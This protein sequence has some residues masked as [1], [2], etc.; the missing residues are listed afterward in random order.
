MNSEYITFSLQGYAMNKRLLTLF[1]AML[2]GCFAFAPVKAGILE[3][4]LLHAVKKSV[5]SAP[6][7]PLYLYAATIQADD[8]DNASNAL[9]TK[10]IKIINLGPA[11]NTGADEYAPTVTA[12]GKTLFFVSNRK[13][14][15]ASDEVEYRGPASDDFWASKKE[16]RLDE[17]QADS[18][19]NIEPEPKDSKST[20]N[21][22]YN[23]G[24]ASISSDGQRLIFT[25]CDRPDGIGSCD[26][27]QTEIDGVKW[28]RPS[29]LG[30]EVNS[31]FWDS[32]PSLSPD[33][34]RIYFASNRLG[35]NNTDS[36]PG[37]TN[38][39][40]WYSDFDEETMKWKPAKNLGNIVN[41]AGE[42]LG[43]FI[44]KDGVTLYFASTGHQPNLG[45][46][47]FYFATLTDPE[48]NVWSKPA[49]IPYPGINSKDDEE[50]ISFP[51][52]GD[53]IYFSSDRSYE[54][55]QGG[56]DIFMAY[57]PPFSR[58]VIIRVLVLDECTGEGIPAAVTIKNKHMGTSKRD[59]L[60]LGKSELQYIV[61]NSDY[62]TG[63]KASEKIEFE[64]VAEN[65]KY[66][67]KS[68]TVTI[69]KPEITYDEEKA[70]E[71][72]EEPP[73]RIMLG[74][75]PSITAEMEYADYIKRVSKKNPSLANWKGLVL[76]EVA[77][78]DLFPL[79]P[80]VFFD[81]TSSAMHP[82]YRLFSSPAQTAGFT[83]ETVKGD[84]N[85][86]TPEKYYD[87]LNIYGYRLKKYPS[88]SVTVTGCN[89]ETSPGEKDL[90]L[91]QRRAQIVYDY[92]KNVWG[93]EESRMKLEKRNL[94]DALVASKT[95]DKDPQSKLYSNIENRRTELTFASSSE[96]DLWQVR[97]PL[98]D[99]EPTIFPTPLTM[100]FQ[101]DNGIDEGLVDSRRIE[102]KRGDAGWVTL[103]NVGKSEKTFTWDWKN[104]AGANL[105]E[106]IFDEASFSARLVVKSINGTECTSDPISIK[107]MIVKN[108]PGVKVE[109]AGAKTRETY[110]LVL[111][112]FNRYDAGPFNERIMKEFVFTRTMP[113]SEIAV[114]GHTD[115][116][117]M[118]ESNAKLST[119][120]AKTV[121][122]AI[123]AAT[124]G[125]FQSL[126]SKGVGED[127]PFF[128]NEL[129]EGRLYNRTVRINIQTPIEEE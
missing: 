104:A 114:E 86:N 97:K 121:E 28:G 129:P 91:S 5:E 27:Y 127:L 1:G 2:I 88:V 113:K 75:K 80:Y 29:N 94:P 125:Q 119:N 101:M 60:K 45:A 50:F 72:K 23:E 107:V 62:G 19:F 37:N 120:R 83:D 6:E 35:P 52:S 79:L 70:K 4:K 124:K 54:R 40:I 68:E 64:I 22:I 74:R 76:E 99:R 55:S 102:V 10:N 21:T 14:S 81:S 77:T 9:K 26:L 85:A 53:V 44:A 84:K 49:P 15:K 48:K 58:A 93:I 109:K 116:I 25:A 67:T 103:T 46:K 34:N 69:I 17:F 43:P 57:V 65:S 115:V 89:D 32:Q 3:G 95:S 42:E 92:L 18:L 96:E 16:G 87:I 7:E 33:G 108:K 78:I 71:S 61:Q 82:R 63:E 118:F 12:D 128:I 47:D 39:D 31:K 123:R 122:T 73:V 98:I 110:K 66:G 13:G 38:Y 51:A 8:D 56:Q 11:I 106:S 30:P 20:V 59:S 117:G 100:N 90:D 36:D 111:F 41:T 24:A 105:T 112:P 126:E